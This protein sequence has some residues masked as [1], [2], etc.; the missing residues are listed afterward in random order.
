M[1]P[2]DEGFWKSLGLIRSGLSPSNGLISIVA[3]P[4]AGGAHLHT[5]LITNPFWQSFLIRTTCRLTLQCPLYWMAVDE[6]TYKSSWSVQ[7]ILV[8]T[9]L[10]QCKIG[11]YRYIPVQWVHTSANQLEDVHRILQVT[12]TSLYQYKLVCTCLYQMPCSR[13]GCQDSR[14]VMSFEIKVILSNIRNVNYFQLAKISNVLSALLMQIFNKG[15]CNFDQVRCSI[16]WSDK[17]YPRLNL[18]P[19]VTSVAQRCSGRLRN[20]VDY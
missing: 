3:L 17:L 16:S 18:E 1:L 11:T 2:V 9:L 12:S 5:K 20:Y 6:K 4:V 10:G 7:H 13:P 19:D 15:S 8:Y 14:W